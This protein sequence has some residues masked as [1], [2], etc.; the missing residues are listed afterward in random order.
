[1]IT[2]QAGPQ[3][4]KKDLQAG[5]SSGDH[6]H[7]MRDELHDV[8]DLLLEAELRPVLEVMRVR[9]QVDHRSGRNLPFFS[10]FE[11]EPDLAERS[12]EILRAE[13]GR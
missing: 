5:A 8:V 2:T 13:L 6:T 11:A 3:F 4:L 7:A 10:S 12:E 9:V 1:V